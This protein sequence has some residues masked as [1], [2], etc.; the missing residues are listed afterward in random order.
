M[1]RQ[2]RHSQA[3]SSNVEKRGNPRNFEWTPKRK[4]ALECLIQAGG[5]VRLAAELSERCSPSVS[6]GYMQ[7][8]KYDEKYRPFR[9]EYQRRT[10]AL[11]DALE[12]KASEWY[13]DRGHSEIPD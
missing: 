13:Q 12:I 8:L 2:D 4:V 3:A 6:Y 11:L 10:G 1:K 5:N 9:K 7:E